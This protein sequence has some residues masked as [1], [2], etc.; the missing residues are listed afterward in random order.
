[1]LTQTETKKIVDQ[2]NEA[3]NKLEK[4]IAALEESQAKPRSTAKKSA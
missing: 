4:R 2:I 3:F 1:M